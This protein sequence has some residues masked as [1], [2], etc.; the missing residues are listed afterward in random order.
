MQ[1]RRDFLKLL[2]GSMGG[3]LLSSCGDSGGTDNLGGIGGGPNGYRFFSLFDSGSV[4]PDGRTLDS[5]PGQVLLNGAGQVLFFG[6]T[7]Q[8]M[9]LYELIPDYPAILRENRGILL[10]SRKLLARGDTLSDGS[11]LLGLGA[12]ASNS[13][14]NKAIVVRTD[15]KKR[16]LLFEPSGG[17]A[18]VVATFRTP[19]PESG[20]RFGGTF[21]DIDLNDQDGLLVVDHYT[22]QGEVRPHQGLFFLQQARVGANTRLLQSSR[23]LLPDAEG[24]VSSIGLV[25]LNS[26]GSYVAQVVGPAPVPLS[27]GSLPP[28]GLL[29]GSV[30]D[31]LASRLLVAPPSFRVSNR[32]TS[33]KFAPGSLI[34]GPRLADQSDIV[35]HIVH[36]TRTQQALFVNSQQVAQVGDRSPGGSTI[37][38]FS[39]PVLSPDGVLYGILI[40]DQGHELVRLSAGGPVLLLARGDTVQGKVVNSVVHGFHSD[41]ADQFGRLVFVGEFMDGSSAVMLGLPI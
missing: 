10:G 29:Q 40:T 21:G 41:Q 8:G 7:A 36:Q 2:A 31:A 23:D 14:G 20:I 39:A 5:L 27:R 19:I 1:R 38:G 6:Q 33:D 12:V 35:A 37:R 22:R 16:N 25:D 9:G 15:Q 32:A 24:T 28:Q 26:N 30:E 13:R 3:L 34:F 18:G 11:R 17:E 4:L